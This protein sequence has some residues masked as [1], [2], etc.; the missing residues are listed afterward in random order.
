MPVPP[1]T[2][3]SSARR[4]NP[5][6]ESY[7]SIS[8]YN[9]YSPSS[10]NSSLNSIPSLPTSSHQVFSPGLPPV[11][12]IRRYTPVRASSYT[13][14]FD[15]PSERKPV[16]FHPRPLRSLTVYSNSPS[17]ERSIERSITR[18]PSPTPSNFSVR[19][20]NSFRS[21]KLGS[22]CLSRRIYPQTYERDDS[23]H[24]SDD[25]DDSSVV[26]DANLT[27][28]LGCKAKLRQNFTPV[29]AHQEAQTA[30][31][32]LSNKISN[33][34]ARTD[35][36]MDEWKGM[37]HKED[38]NHS[39]RLKRHGG[40]LPGRSRSATNI[41]I[42]GYQYFSRANSC[43]RSSVARESSVGGDITDCE[44][45]GSKLEIIINTLNLA[46]PNIKTPKNMYFSRLRKV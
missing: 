19:S 25:K 9:G 24:D 37:G 8:G 38:E 32:E 2:Y 33:F 13:S 17:S 28:V 5:Y 3:F 10:S 7:P 12:P 14:G 22:T 31:N 29:P 36:V 42:K 11:T 18:S 41:M 34:L 23:T 6:L 1:S 15:V 27:F 16:L 30:S 44:E 26:F 46:C 20:N 45:V 39:Y 40:K 4:P 21:D 43:S 35:H